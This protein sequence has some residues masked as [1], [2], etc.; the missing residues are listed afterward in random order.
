M[1]VDL[2]QIPKAEPLPVPPDRTRW[3]LVIALVVI[4]GAVLVLSLWPKD[5]TTH[6]AWFWFCTLLV[7]F[8]AGLAGYIVRLRHYENERDRVM[9]WNFLHQTQHDEQVSLGR[10]ALGVLGMSYSTPVASNKLA[11][12]L[13]QGANALQSHYS[14]ALQSV[15]TSA[16]LSPA[17]KIPD[18]EEHRSRLEVLLGRVIRQ[19]HAELTQ[20]T[21]KLVVRLHHDGLLKNEQIIAVWQSVFSQSYAA[22]EVNVTTESDGVM[23][24]DEWLD[25]QDD[26]LLLSVEINLFLLVRDREA[27]SVSALLLASPAYLERRH[28]KPQMWI[29]RPVSVRDADSAVADTANWGKVTSGLPWYFWRAQVK[30]DALA[31]VLQVMDKYG[32]LSAKKGEQVL[33]V[34][35]GRPAVAVGNITLICA[36]EHALTSGMPQWLLIDDQTTQMAIVRPA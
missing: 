35:F 22:S 10:Q 2:K 17:L 24:V 26:T 4:A 6:S 8:F 9:W 18:E 14:Q 7:P 11:A 33:D 12:A 13:L 23:W 29:H 20:F 5:L 25:R 36:C 15:V 32:F 3:F 16:L 19:L 27:E 31:A 28:I 1:P 21:G 34:S 30:N